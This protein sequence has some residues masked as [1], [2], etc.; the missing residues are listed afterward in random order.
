MA[1]GRCMFW[2]FHRRE[3]VQLRVVLKMRCG[4]HLCID[5]IRKYVMTRRPFIR[6]PYRAKNYNCQIKPMCTDWIIYSFSF[7]HVNKVIGVNS[8]WGALRAGS[9]SRT[10]GAIWIQ[11][12]AD[13]LRQDRLDVQISL[14]VQ[15]LTFSD[16]ELGNAYS[17][18]DD[19]ASRAGIFAWCKRMVALT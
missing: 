16:V 18:T 1:S 7:N 5:C 2:F 6:S 19:D 11:M 9:S 8:P 17:S 15:Y 14:N 13:A 4:H 12:V 3:A 10:L